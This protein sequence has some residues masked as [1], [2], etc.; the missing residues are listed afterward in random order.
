MNRR[1]FMTALFGSAAATALVGTVNAVST[2]D[3]VLVAEEEAVFKELQERHIIK[4]YS[5]KSFAGCSDEMRNKNRI[6]KRLVHKNRVNIDFHVA[7]KNDEADATCLVY[8]LPGRGR[9]PLE[10]YE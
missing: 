6:L 8:Y 10:T 9:T 7:D 2:D 4:I 1:G 5:R 3:E